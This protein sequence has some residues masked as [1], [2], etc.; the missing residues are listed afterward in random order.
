MIELRFIM[1]AERSE[2]PPRLQWREWMQDDRG[3]F[4]GWG[5]WQDVPTVV[6]ERL[7]EPAPSVAGEILGL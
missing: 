6:A 2:R 5:E 1:D 3:S 4:A 7:A